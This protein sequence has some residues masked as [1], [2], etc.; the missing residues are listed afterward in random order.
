MNSVR[1]QGTI[2]KWDEA[3][4]F[5]FIAPDAG[6]VDVFAH[7]KSVVGGRRPLTGDRVFYFPEKDQKGRIRA[8]QIQFETSL[9][10]NP[11]RAVATT[12][13]AAFVAAHVLAAA[14]GKITPVVPVVYVMMSAVTFGAYAHDKA[15]SR[16]AGQ[17]LSENALHGLELCGGW[18]GALLA[19]QWLRHKNRKL[20]YQLLFWSI[21]SAHIGAWIF[22]ASKK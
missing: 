6:G 16:R 5:G 15:S 17:R 14:L 1:Q 10:S 9:P 2:V 22:V 11:C 18:P 8:L 12:F 21:V 3:K 20:S 13:A 19:Q 4:S 7:I